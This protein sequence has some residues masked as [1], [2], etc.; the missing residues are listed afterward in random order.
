MAWHAFLLTGS[1]ALSI[2]GCGVQLTPPTFA[3][4]L[5]SISYRTVALSSPG[6]FAP[7]A[8]A[9]SLAQHHRTSLPASIHLPG[10]YR[11]EHHYLSS[12]SICTA[13]G[14]V[15]L[16]QIHWALELR[17]SQKVSGVCKG[18]E[19]PAELFTPGHGREHLLDD[20]SRSG[21][22]CPALLGSTQYVSNVIRM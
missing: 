12:T 5:L 22:C 18:E 1:D 17:V 6:P 7:P 16:P 21:S 10:I 4:L 15:E 9:Y 11:Y 13:S 20:S 3:P 8:F 19:L 2:E 14:T